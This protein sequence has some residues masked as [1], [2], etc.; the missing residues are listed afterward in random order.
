LISNQTTISS[1]NNASSNFR[2]L[3]S[4]PLTTS[5]INY[6]SEERF[7]PE[8]ISLTDDQA[9]IFDR[10]RD[11]TTGIHLVTGSSGCEKSFFINYMKQYWVAQG[12]SVLLAATTG[13]AAICLDP[14]ATTVHS[15]FNIPVKG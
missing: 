15:T 6:T 12:K 9:R 4:T 10:L 11:R 3:L 8:D 5:L 2:S 14:N 13:V 1:E 7:Q